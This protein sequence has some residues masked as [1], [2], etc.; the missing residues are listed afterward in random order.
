MATTE[1]S[2]DRDEV[3]VWVIYQDP[4]DYPGKFVVRRQVAG[5]GGVTADREPVAV[6]ESIEAARA[7]LPSGLYRMHRHSE[8][9]PVIVETWI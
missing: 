7:V 6:V 8:D 9:D 1:E 4:S 2:L 3:R 5:R